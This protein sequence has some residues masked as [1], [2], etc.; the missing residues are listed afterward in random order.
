MIDFINETLKGPAFADDERN[1]KVYLLRISLLTVFTGS[2]VGLII[3]LLT[4]HWSLSLMFGVMITGTVISFFL[5]KTGKLRFAS[6]TMLLCL[7]A[8][9][10]LYLSITDGI[11]DSI[12][13]IFPILILISSMLLE[14]RDYIAYASILFL[15]MQGLILCEF[16]GI[17]SNKMSHFISPIDII[18]WGGLTI[19]LIGLGNK[20][21]DS[22]RRSLNR[23]NQSNHSLQN[24]I[25][26]RKQAEDA[27]REYSE[28]LEAI[29]AERT[30]ELQDAQ[31]KLLR[32]E[33]LAALGE[34]AGS[35]GHEL[36]NPLGV[37]S[38]ALYLLRLTL[39]GIDEKTHELLDIIADAINKSSKIIS[40]LLDFAR[41]KPVDRQAIIVAN[42]VQRTLATSTIPDNV[43]VQ[44]ISPTDLPLLY[45]DAQQIEQVL[46][47]LVTNACQAMAEG[48]QL[49]IA[50]DLYPSSRVDASDKS[51]ETGHWI[52]ITV[53]DTG[54][55]IPTENLQKIFEPLFT[56][57]SL[58]IG[59]GLA[60]SKKLVEANDGYIEV[61]SQP[62]Q[63]TIFTV[64]LP[65]YKS[66]L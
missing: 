21:S 32:Q 38:N 40:A 48:G 55:G 53:T 37:I 35:V 39:S 51:A 62:G 9:L 22:I 54:S 33:R 64:S 65:V 10:L 50:S 11:H 30:R 63:G 7:L 58:G 47:N 3:G 23:V 4:S 34:L 5:L 45:V 57:K 17:I 28:Q 18:A 19:V 61:N 25:K 43:S 13:S 14:K 56:T 20:F 27:L 60:I 31:E 1:N 6:L 15:S 49:T 2:I 16:T 59:L 52:Q 42:L 12:S 24:E 36:R 26:Q 46:V 8:P 41:I 29:V 66:G 44:I